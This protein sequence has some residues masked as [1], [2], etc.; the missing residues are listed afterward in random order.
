MSIEKPKTVCDLLYCDI[1]VTMVVWNQTQNISEVFLHIKVE[2]LLIPCHCSEVIAVISFLK[3]LNRNGFIG[4]T[5]L[6]NL[7]F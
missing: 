6:Y 5:L 4:S 7:V 3:M 1:H 2:S